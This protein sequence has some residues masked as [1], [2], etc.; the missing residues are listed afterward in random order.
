MVR[1]K[2]LARPPARKVGAPPNMLARDSSGL[3]LPRPSPPQTVSVSRRVRA[4]H[5]IHKAFLTQTTAALNLLS[6]GLALSASPFPV[7]HSKSLSTALDGLFISERVTSF[8]DACR[9]SGGNDIRPSTLQ[10]ILPQLSRGEFLSPFPGNGSLAGSSGAFSVGPVVPSSTGPSM[11]ESGSSIPKQPYLLTAN[12]AATTPLSS[13]SHH[14]SHTDTL[15]ARSAQSRN[16]APT[17]API[18][19]DTLLA[20]HFAYAAN[21]NSSD[22]GAIQI[23]ADLVSLPARAGT[24]DVLKFLP[25]DM[26]NSLRDP[27]SLLKDRPLTVAHTAP[28]C[29]MVREGHYAKLLTRMATSGMIKWSAQRPVM[30]NGLFAV[31]KPDGTQRLIIDARRANEAFVDPPHVSLPTPDLLS[32]LEADNR[33]V[34]AKADVSDYFHALRMP[35]PWWEYFGL[36]SVAPAE[37]GMA[38]T[39]PSA[40]RIWPLICTLPMGFHMSVAV[41][42]EF[43]LGFISSCVPLLPPEARVS[44]LAGDLRINRLRYAV[45]VDDLTL[46]ALDPGIADEALQQYIDAAHRE[47]LLIKPNKTSFSSSKGIEVTGL[48]TDGMAGTIGVSAP[49]LL[50]LCERTL[51]IARSAC[52]SEA[53]VSAVVGKWT[54][55]ALVRRPTLSVFGAIYKWIRAN[56]G[57][58]APLWPS[59]RLELAVMCA[60]APLLVADLSIPWLP[61]TLAFDASSRGQG[62]RSRHCQLQSS[63]HWLRQ[64]V[65]HRLMRLLLM[66]SSMPPSNKS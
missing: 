8:L 60:L 59:A 31:P 27:S 38:S 21:H 9:A 14:D 11:P 35:E 47:G 16:P 41:A 58:C 25:A 28:A 24:C 22:A 49:K 66:T 18:P 23:D 55:A 6:Q 54:W 50:Q 3:C 32:L 62:S 13:A 65:D 12:A 40:D 45:Y 20:A 34:V 17:S 29:V 42:Q 53:D 15:S 52:V 37:V 48:A 61:S 39:F 10:T 4:R 7:E 63:L 33:F 30:V 64:R 36:P 51:A 57:R 46:F 44:T 43:H 26:A 2:A 19:R 1:A 5:N 56:D